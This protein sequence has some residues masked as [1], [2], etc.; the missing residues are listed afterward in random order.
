MRRNA[1]GVLLCGV[2]VSATDHKQ[3]IVMRQDVQQASDHRIVRRLD[4][5]SH[6]C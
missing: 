6:T 5:F 3:V 2:E 1:F 4:I